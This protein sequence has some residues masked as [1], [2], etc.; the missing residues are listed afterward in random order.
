MRAQDRVQQ[1]KD[2]FQSTHASTLR[3]DAI[4]DKACILAPEMSHIGAQT[5]Y[6]QGPRAAFESLIEQWPTCIRVTANIQEPSEQC[7]GAG[8]S[9]ATSYDSERLSASGRPFAVSNGE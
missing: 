6:I 5:T 8:M 2:S 7:I 4:H 1:A 9:R 3:T